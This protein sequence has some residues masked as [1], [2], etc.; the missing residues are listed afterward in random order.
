MTDLRQICSRQALEL[1]RSGNK[2]E[3]L[4]V[5][6][7]K[8]DQN[9]LCRSIVLKL[10]VWTEHIFQLLRKKSS[11]TFNHN[12]QNFINMRK[13]NLHGTQSELLPLDHKATNTVIYAQFNY[14]H[15]IFNEY[16]SNSMTLYSKYLSLATDSSWTINFKELPIN[17]REKLITNFKMTMPYT[18]D[19]FKWCLL[20]YSMATCQITCWYVYKTVIIQAVRIILFDT[21]NNTFIEL[22][23][24]KV[25]HVVNFKVLKF[26]SLEIF[27]A[28]KSDR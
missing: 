23:P 18:F 24:L 6:T 14:M 15:V 7:C 17:T 8:T 25:S 4:H 10:T 20:D 12:F 9:T 16:N 19:N 11:E 5:A 22:F 13:R 27:Q 26:Q 1:L 21:W 2:G 3:I 28:N